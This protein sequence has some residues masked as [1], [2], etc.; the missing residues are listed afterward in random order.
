MA[1]QDMDQYRIAEEPCYRA[2]EDE[3]ALF[4]PARYAVVDQVERL[5]ESLSRLFMALAR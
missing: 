2:V 4:G 5:P 1:T 3:V